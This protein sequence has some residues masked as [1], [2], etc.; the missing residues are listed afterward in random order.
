MI[1]G[2]TRGGR[3]LNRQRDVH[4]EQGHYAFEADRHG[5][6]CIRRPC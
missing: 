3:R 1:H 2:P 4:G 6:S 5:E